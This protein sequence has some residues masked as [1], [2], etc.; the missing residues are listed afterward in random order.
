MKH[1][2]IAFLLILSLT[3]NAQ[4][5]ISLPD[6]SK[7]IGDSVE[8]TTQV[9]GVKYLS[10][11]KGSP[12]LVNFGAPY[13]N[14]LL[15][16]VIWSNVRTQM[17]IEPTEENLKDK[18]VI[19]IGKVELYKGKPQVVIKGPAQFQVV[20]KSGEVLPFKN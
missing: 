2:L 12:T 19:V 1:L 6:I 8:L 13:P 4:T 20:D 17:L 14:Q 16:A 9:F 5:K 3:V 10:D 15:T 7:H 18:T 11:A